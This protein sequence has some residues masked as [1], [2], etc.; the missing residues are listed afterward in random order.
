MKKQILFLQC[1]KCLFLKMCFGVGNGFSDGKF[2]NLLLSS[3]ILGIIVEK[4]SDF[5][6]K[7]HSTSLRTTESMRRYKYEDFFTPCVR[8]ISSSGITTCTF[9][10]YWP[11]FVHAYITVI[12]A[13]CWNVRPTEAYPKLSVLSVPIVNNRPMAS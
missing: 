3:S 10:L 13:L 7:P 5:V 1:Q 11:Y 6:L 2:C 4:N 9:I 12:T 8:N